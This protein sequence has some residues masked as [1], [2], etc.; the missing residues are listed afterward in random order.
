MQ[1]E[2]Q[3]AADKAWAYAW[4]IRKWGDGGCADYTNTE[5]VK[6]FLAGVA[7]QKQVETRGARWVEKWNPETERMEEFL[8][9]PLRKESMRGSAIYPHMRGKDSVTIIRELRKGGSR[10]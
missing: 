10:K 2:K 7:W 1:S 9:Y 8:C 6:A 5:V 3:K 4:R